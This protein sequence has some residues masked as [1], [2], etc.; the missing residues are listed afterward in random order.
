[1]LACG[2]RWGKTTL[3]LDLLIDPALDGQPVA[4]FT[5]TYKMLDEFWR[6]LCGTCATVTQAK[7]A[8]LHRL[9][10]IT[11]G[12]IDMWSLTEPNV[13]RGRRYARAVIDEAAQIG[14]LLAAWNAVIRP[15]LAD[16]EGDAWFLSTP[17]GHNDF[18]TLYGRAGH[19]WRAWQR[20]TSDNPHIATHEVAAMRRDLGDL[21]AAQ[22][23]DAE[24]ID[25]ETAERYLPSI[26]WWDACRADLP[27]LDTTT[28]IV[29]A[30]DA[31]V[32][33]DSFGLVGVTR[34][35]AHEGHVAVRFVR[36]WEPH[37]GTIDFDVV[38]QEIRAICATW[39]VIQLVYDPYQLHHMM[40]R[41]QNDGV[42]WT[43]K[44][45]QGA[46]RFEADKQL[47]DLIV[48]RQI[49]HDG[50]TQLRAHL[51]NAD[52]KV[53]TET[54]KLRIIKRRDNAKVDLAVSLSMA[55]ARCLRLNL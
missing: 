19:D 28:P 7:N 10:L 9:D 55:A 6:L 49:T 11:G 2:R 43:H 31:G 17:H 27:P 36:A 48:Q 32:S 50:N 18:E 33:N 8:S 42:V 41:L 45:D 14:D 40:S 35:P 26:L 13:A 15:T 34:H 46:A 53:D 37:G 21:Y 52:R 47:L 22:E 44:F 51:D 20:P 12:I 23:V 5:P 30:A 39:D 54:R 1:M 3:A 4:Y 25:A 16:Y 29:L 24:F 38:E